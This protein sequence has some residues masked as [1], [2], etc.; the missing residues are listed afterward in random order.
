[1]K[2]KLRIVHKLNYR[3]NPDFCDVYD[4]EAAMTAR[5]WT[6]RGEWVGREV[7]I[8]ERREHQHWYGYAWVSAGTDHWYG[9]DTFA[10]F[11]EAKEALKYYDGTIEQKTV[12]WESP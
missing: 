3:F 9:R 6:V 2:T 12:V 8:I 10:T 4:Q 7:Y 11:D 5:N 1:M